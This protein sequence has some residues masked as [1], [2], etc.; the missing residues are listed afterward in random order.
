M[1]IHVVTDNSPPKPYVSLQG[2]DKF[3]C[4][5]V[6]MPTTSVNL[7]RGRHY[8]MMAG[9]CLSVRSSVCLSRDLLENGKSLEAQNWQDWSPSYVNLFGG[10]KVKDQSHQAD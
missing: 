8:K 2:P 1:N 9:V 7:H 5:L 4:Y 10:Q 6:I 3:V